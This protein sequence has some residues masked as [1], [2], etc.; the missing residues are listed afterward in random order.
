MGVPGAAVAADAPASVDSVRIT[1]GKTVNLNPNVPGDHRALKVQLRISGTADP[2][3]VVA[4]QMAQYDERG[5]TRVI[6]ARINLDPIPLNLQGTSGDIS[7]YVGQATFADLQVAGARIPEGGKALL[8]ID[9]ATATSRGTALPQSAAAQSEQGGTQCITVRHRK[10]T[11]KEANS[12][13][14][15]MLRNLKMTKGDGAIRYLTFTA[16]DLAHFADRPARTAETLPF[17]DLANK[18]T[19]RTTFEQPAPVVEVAI[20]GTT[21]HVPLRM[22][23]PVSLGGDRYRAKVRFVSSSRLTP[24]AVAGQDLAFFASATPVKK[25]NPD[26]CASQSQTLADGYAPGGSDF[27]GSL[28]GATVTAT[29]GADHLLLQSTDPLFFN[30]YLGAGFGC[31]ARRTGATDFADLA[32]RAGWGQLFG[33][34]NPNSALLWEDGPRTQVL[35][36]EQE[37]PEYDAASG[38]WTSKVRPFFGDEVP[39]PAT[40]NRFIKKFGTDLTVD[41]PYLFMDA[42]G[43]VNYGD[44]VMVANDDFEVMY[45][46]LDSDMLNLTFHLSNGADGWM[47]VCFN[48]FMFPADCIVAWIDPDSGVA[49][50]WDAYNPGIPTLSFFPSPTKD[51]NP[52]IT[53][54]GG[55]P[56]DNK[57]NVNITSYTTSA[58]AGTITI[59]LQRLMQTGDLFD[60]QF[61]PGMQL[62]VVWAYSSDQ[63]FFNDLDAMQPE[64][65]EYGAWRWMF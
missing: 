28:A 21:R 5:G 42:I 17:A 10:G 59:N 41:A 32:T 52:V 37:M 40:V 4:V 45:S 26:N 6:P 63:V 19:W 57:E 27:V 2:A 3:P 50:V 46:T 53:L 56:L 33:R 62:N 49:M 43:S 15:G 29:P 44:V 48:E 55:S 61:A 12:L 30:W 14:T 24:A 13:F 54:Q 22:A 47:G 58:E 34:I 11:P 9:T 31:E 7:T 38:T 36:F 23:A 20:D 1:S 35:E 39:S 18:P 25:P 16:Q 60:Y 65:T 64:H 51:D 8:C